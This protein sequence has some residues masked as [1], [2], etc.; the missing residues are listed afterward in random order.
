MLR[1]TGVLNTVLPTRFKLKLNRQLD[2]RYGEDF[3]LYQHNWSN[4]FS[5]K[6]CGVAA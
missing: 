1:M 2:S 3:M 4:L 5:S 6:L